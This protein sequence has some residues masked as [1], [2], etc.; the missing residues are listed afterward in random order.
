MGIS[1]PFCTRWRH[2]SIRGCQRRG[3]IVPNLS[4][5]TGRYGQRTPVQLSLIRQR[6]RLTSNVVVSPDA[7]FT[8]MTIDTN[9][10]DAVL[11]YKLGP[12]FLADDDSV[13][14]PL[15]DGSRPSLDIERLDP[16]LNMERDPTLD[17]DRLDPNLAALLSPNDFGV[18]VSSTP[19]KKQDRK[20]FSRQSVSADDLTLT[21]TP[22]TRLREAATGRDRSGSDVVLLGPGSGRRSPLPNSANG[23]PSRASS[24]KRTGRLGT[25]VIPDRLP[26]P[27]TPLQSTTKRSEQRSPLRRSTITIG[28]SSPNAT[29]P[30][31]RAISAED[32]TQPQ[33]QPTPT[34][35]TRNRIPLFEKVRTPISSPAISHSR[36]TVRTS[37]DWRER[38]RQRD[39]ERLERQRD[40]ER[41]E[42][43]AS[44]AAYSRRLRGDSPD[45][46][47]SRITT[48]VPPRALTSFS[49]NRPSAT[50][51][52]MSAGSPGVR[53]R[54]SYSIDH[55]GDGTRAFVS[56]RMVSGEKDREPPR[57]AGLPTSKSYGWRE[58]N[59]EDSRPSLSRA[60]TLADI[61]PTTTNRHYSKDSVSTTEERH[62]S[63]PSSA[64]GPSRTLYAPST[65][66]S[67]GNLKEP[68]RNRTPSPTYL[69]TITV[70]SHTETISLLKERHEL[71]KDALVSAMTEMKRENQKLIKEKTE[72]AQY[73]TELEERLAKSEEMNRKMDGLRQAVMEV[74]GGMAGEPETRRSSGSRRGGDG[75]SPL[76]VA[77]SLSYRQYSDEPQTAATRPGPVVGVV[78]RERRC[79]RGTRTRLV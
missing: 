52:P 34:P 17:V 51:R 20:R 11:E 45:R 9:A 68:G 58:T 69:P 6:L 64:S 60:S 33:P 30:R 70:S 74:A 31:K 35:E 37:L 56:R 43:P 25:L 40:G 14:S 2:I 3:A 27:V 24:T 63:T 13:K 55:A 59:E 65:T 1:I 53:K 10:I 4:L 41:M 42:R 50:P 71:E 18:V 39:L 75:A 36:P 67:G 23:S 61:A 77:T 22:T 62:P 19:L 48:P 5:G 57:S 38:E 49:F 28:T 16:D 44:S 46:P 7:S 78:E 26:P 21:I 76:R 72:M 66:S 79:R 54:R 32:P 15:T 8:S 47:P 12:N 73:I 29:S